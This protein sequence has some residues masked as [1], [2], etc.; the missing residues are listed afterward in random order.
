[1]TVVVA[2]PITWP[3]VAELKVTWNWP[4]ASVVPEIE[5]GLDAG[6][7]AGALVS[8]TAPFVPFK[9]TVTAAPDAGAKPLKASPPGAPAGRP[10]S[11]STSAVNVCGFPTS[12]VPFGV[13]VI[14]ASRGG[15][16]SAGLLPK[17]NDSVA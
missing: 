14:R 5:L 12:L 1:M 7:S 10:S 2:L 13:I 11:A 9:L 4:L 17:L 15:G 8:G 6:R 16:I 3:A